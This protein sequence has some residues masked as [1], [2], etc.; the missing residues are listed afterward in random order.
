MSEFYF[1]YYL[2]NKLMDFDEILCLQYCDQ[3]MKFSRTFQQLG[4]LIDV[5]SSIFFSI[6]LEIMNGF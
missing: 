2:E 5:K 6:Y 1:Q 3:Q 4:P